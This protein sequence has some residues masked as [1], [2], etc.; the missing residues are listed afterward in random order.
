MGA[1]T[2]NPRYE[3]DKL[4]IAEEALG[5]GGLIDAHLKWVNKD[6]SPSANIDQRTYGY[7][8]QAFTVEDPSLRPKLEPIDYLQVASDTLG[9][10]Y[11]T[12]YHELSKRVGELESGWLWF[13][14]RSGAL[15]EAE[16]TEMSKA[17]TNAFLLDTLTEDNLPIYTATNFGGFQALADKHGKELPAVDE[18][19]RGIWTSEEG[20]HGN[21]MNQYGLM[22]DMLNNPE[23]VAGRNSQLRAGMEVEL[24]NVSQLFAYVAWQELST[25]YAHKRNGALLGPIGARVL[26]RIAKDEARHHVVYNGVVK[27]FYEEFP[28]DT[29]MTLNS[30]LMDPVMPG[31]KGIPGFK[32]RALKIHGSGIFSIGQKDEAVRSIMKKLSLYDDDANRGLSGEEFTALSELRERYPLEP[33][34]EIKRS[35]TRFVLGKTIT[36]AELAELRRDYEKSVGIDPRAV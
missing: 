1:Y 3:V 32:R 27:R 20:A 30:E 18:W 25:N 17:S 26:S 23:H 28:G 36:I 9:V 19:G 13:V 11:D 2:P 34:E 6:E 14:V 12:P 31:L 4:M 21:A 16:A 10:P 5:A 33:Q 7:Q 15:S 35:S 24:Q 8:P 22:T 29:I